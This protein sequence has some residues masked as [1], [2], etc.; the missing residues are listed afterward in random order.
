MYLVRTEGIYTTGSHAAG[1]VW[2]LASGD[3][4]ATRLFGVAG[5]PGAPRVALRSRL[6][7][8]CAVA[9]VLMTE[10]ASGLRFGQGDWLSRPNS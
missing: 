8:R 1:Q 2:A 7:A 5:T 4:D 3:A 9:G 6:G 10:E